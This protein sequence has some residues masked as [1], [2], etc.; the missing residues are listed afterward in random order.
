VSI[1]LEIMSLPSE[2]KRQASDTGGPGFAVIDLETTGVFT[3][4]DRIVEVGV[5]LLDV[6]GDVIEEWD[7]LVN[8]AR[9]VGPTGIH[10][11]RPRDLVD[12]PAFAD[13]ASQLADLL[14]GRVPVA[15]NV[16]FDL[17]FLLSEYSALGYPQMPLRYQNGICTMHLARDYLPYSPRSLG[18][19]CR[20]AGWEPDEQHAALA[21]AR[22]SARLFHHY[23]GRVNGDE[24][25]LSLVDEAPT[26]DWPLV[27][28]AGDGR[29]R[30]PR[31]QVR[32]DREA[33]S[34]GAG[35]DH[36]LARLLPG[37]PRVT[38]PAAAE[39]YLSVLDDVL[40]DRRIDPGE[41]DELVDLAVGFGL[42]R[43][44]VGTLHRRYLL[45]LA[46]AAWEDGQVTELERQDL[47]DVAELLGLPRA[48]VAEAIDAVRAYSPSSDT[49]SPSSD[50]P[51]VP[52]GSL[53][54]SAGDRICFTGDMSRPRTELRAVAEAAGLVVTG[55]VS[56]KTTVLV[57]ADAASLSGKAQRARQLGTTVI[58]EPKFHQLMAAMNG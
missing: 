28:G 53:T 10:G 5:V 9:D 47:F 18:D 33:R 31:Q 21:D 7:T 2:K 29:P 3:R 16:A 6:Y 42:D 4:R 48:A 24:P 36:F 34:R 12:A 38:T 13:I 56:G 52:R 57:C 27:P 35:P 8:P 1:I 43:S 49:P 14:T 51:D 17:R 50:A 37:L 19:C 44:S 23:L 30:L 41:A 11:I 32:T 15:H 26:W 58:S 46:R 45:G 39:S 40:A 20:T 22:A 54:L 25:W 55:S